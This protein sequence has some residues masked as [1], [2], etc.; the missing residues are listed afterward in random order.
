MLTT[1]QIVNR[2]TTYACCAMDYLHKFVQAD[3][4]GDT[5]CANDSWDKAVLMYWAQEQMCDTP[6]LDGETGCNTVEF[7]TQ[8]AS[9]ADCFCK[10]CGCEPVSPT[11][12]PVPT[13]C[14]IT[15]NYTVIAAVDVDQRLIIEADSPTVGDS[16]YVVTDSGGSG[17]TVNT[18]VTWNGGGWDAVTVQPNEVIFATQTNAYWTPG[19]NN[20]PGLLFPPLI[21]YLVAF[22]NQY[23]IQS[24]YPWISNLLG[25]NAL[26]RGFVNGTW[27][28][29]YSGPESA[30]AD[31]TTYDFQALPITA[32]HVVYLVGDCQYTAGATVIPPF[33]ECGTIAATITA[34][35]DCGTN[36]FF[37]IVDIEQVDGWPLGNIIVTLN[38]SPLAPVAASLGVTLL[39]PYQTGDVVGIRITNAQDSECDFDAGNYQDPNIPIADRTVVSAVDAS[40]QGSASP[41]TPYLIV[42][43]TTGAGN[44]WA[45]HV[46][47]FY[48][49][50]IFFPLTEGEVVQ[51]Q[52][53][54]GFD[55]F[56]QRV[57]G[58][59]V[60]MY[61]GVT[62]VNNGAYPFP[63]S[64]MSAS[65]FSATTRFRPTV[66]EGLYG[67]VWQPIWAGVESDLA[68]L[69]PFDLPSVPS[70]VRVTYYGTQCPITVGGSIEQNPIVF[71]FSCP[72]RTE[73][74]GSG[75]LYD[76]YYDWNDGLYLITSD[77]SDLINSGD[78]LFENLAIGDVIGVDATYAFTPSPG[79]VLYLSNGGG[80][81]WI[82]G[83][84]PGEITLAAYQGVAQTF[85]FQT[86]QQGL[87]TWL[88]TAPVGQ[89]VLLSFWEGGMPITTIIRLWSNTSAT[90]PYIDGGSYPTLPPAAFVSSGNNMFMEAEVGAFGSGTP[91]VFSVQC[92]PA[93]FFPSGGVASIDDCINLKFSISGEITDVGDSDGGLVDVQYV[94]DGQV[95]TISGIG[96]ADPFFTIGPF[97][98][99]A[100]VQVYIRHRNNP[101]C[102][103]FL[104]TF[105]NQGTCEIPDNPCLPEALLKVDYQGDLSELPPT[106][107]NPAISNT[108]YVVSDNT[109][110]GTFAPGDV[111]AWNVPNQEWEYLLTVPEGAFIYGGEQ[112]VIGMVGQFTVYGNG[113]SGPYNAF[114]P[115]LVSPN[116]YAVS[117]AD[118]W[119][120]RIAEVG[121]GLVTTDR[122]VALQVLSGGEW[123]QVW[124]GT[125]QQLG[126]VNLIEI[127]IPFT[128]TR[129][130]YNYDTCAVEVAYV[131]DPQQGIEQP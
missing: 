62:L 99:D 96:L 6:V 114:A 22:N 63:W 126:P 94:Y 127:P 118:A 69:Q 58:L 29:I 43:D 75:D 2:R 36:E 130:V 89:Q 39:G 44:T 49:G 104:G 95:F 76:I 50:A 111:L 12:P 91:W 108:F 56:W 98:Y 16:Y 119:R 79:D 8:V 23:V 53:E 9:K 46:G 117:E 25:R 42:S 86:L 129:A 82:V 97:P 121:D 51:T 40:F 61:P 90:P 14:T 107:D 10:Q 109:D 41:G 73:I 70:E 5:K 78:P 131:I 72:T 7:A 4:Y 1:Q 113:P 93:N 106:P 35:R 30:L 52:T 59:T 85:S 92:V 57:N 87:H 116:P 55:K 38:G 103:V 60:Q 66:V 112:T 67:T 105:T 64:L 3:I 71:N 83:D 18:V 128:L 48:N 28:I 32:L 47:E 20:E 100:Q 88:F 33:G 21:G 110:I 125:E 102:D 11:V 68:T 19:T 15:P 84:T 81:Y 123:V 17:W 26:V 54:T 80:S 34:E 124:T 31:P 115:I 37:V 27:Q 74:L 65:P 101:A 24:T 45:D 120:I 13:D 122:P 77:D